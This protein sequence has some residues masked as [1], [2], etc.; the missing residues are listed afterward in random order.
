MSPQLSTRTFRSLSASASSRRITLAR[1]WFRFSERSHLSFHVLQPVS[2]EQHPQQLV[3]W[4]QAAARGNEGADGK[5]PH[6]VV[7]ALELPLVAP[8]KAGCPDP[9][10]GWL[11]KEDPGKRLWALG[12]AAFVID[13]HRWVRE[14]VR[15]CELQATDLDL[16]LNQSDR[17]WGRAKVFPRIMPRKHNLL[18]VGYGGARPAGRLHPGPLGP[19]RFRQDPQE[20]LFCPAHSA[21]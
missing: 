6:G 11:A 4:T 3:C 12:Q 10:S 21:S 8:V 18:A 2:G 20:L 15:A 1:F 19:V 5:S 17:V 9:V 7:D 16:Q 14:V 13:K